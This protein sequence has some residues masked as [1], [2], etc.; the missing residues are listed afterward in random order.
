[1]PPAFDVAQ[2]AKDSDARMAAAQQP[3]SGER[4]TDPGH[5]SEMRL[6]TRPNLGPVMTDEAWARSM[7]GSPAVVMDPESLKRLPLDHKVGF[8]LSLMDGK[9][10]LDTLVAVAS[11]PRDQ[12]LRAVRDLYESGVVE[13]R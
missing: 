1:M 5:Q 10:D 2:Y 8:L 3:D 12:V 7:T 11:M 9:T 6:L 13:F 4:P